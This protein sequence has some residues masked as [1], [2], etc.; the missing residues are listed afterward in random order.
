MTTNQE[1]RSEA[2][3]RLLADSYSLYLKTQK[4][5]WN[6]TGP[7]FLTL[8]NF[9][10]TQYKELATAIDEIAE[11]LRALGVTAPGSFTQFMTLAAVTEDTGTPSAVEMIRRLLSDQETIGASARRLADAAAAVGDEGSADLAVRRRLVHQKSAW[12]LR[13]QLE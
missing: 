8:H 13:S 11:R 9:F 5:H 1:L 12:M 10:E 2:L 6:V 3:K 4:F 7:M